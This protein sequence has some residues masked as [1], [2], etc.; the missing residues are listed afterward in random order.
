[1]YLK[2][3]TYAYKF[4][5][6]DSWMNDPENPRTQTDQQ[7][8]INSLISKGD[9]YTFTLNGFQEAKKVV[10]TGSFNN[11][12]TDEMLM[13]KT[14]GGWKLPFAL[15]PGNYEYKFI[16]DGSWIT[17]PANPYS[18]GTGNRINSAL[19]INPNYT[20]T[21]SGIE[22]ATEI[23]VAGTFNE[24]NP[25]GYRMVKK[26]GIWTFPVYLEKGKHLYKYIVDGEWIIDPE[27]KNW[28]QNEHGTG[29]SVLWVR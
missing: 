11:W 5:V 3:G 16:V 6:D 10:L 20:F 21:L 29:N 17:D 15:S 23:I 28:E 26:N 13:E 27:N 1:M 24:W 9:E 25:D 7:G 8:N 19:A 22:E 18:S 2:D 12:N 14:P 4:M